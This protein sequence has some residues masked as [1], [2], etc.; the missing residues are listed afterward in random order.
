YLT[1]DWDAHAKRE[2][3]EES[4]RTTGKVGAPTTWVLS[5]HDVARHVTRYG[6]GDHALGLRRARA[7]AL[8]MLA[9]PGSTYIYQGEELGLPEVVELPD[10][11]R[12]DPSFFRSD[13]QEGLRD[14]CRVPL[15]WSGDQAPY[16]FGPGGSWL[17]QPDSFK[18]LTVEAQTGD[19]RSTLE[20]YRSALAL[21][22]EL[23]GL[24]DGPM[25]WL[26]APDGVLAVGRPGVV[27]TL[28]TTGGTVEVPTPGRLLIASVAPA[29]SG[30][31]TALS[32][33][34]CAWWAI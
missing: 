6:G 34:S 14:G 31:T 12:Q 8:L 11:V 32:A 26:P 5:N 13:G 18:G 30:A 4:L 27:C 9:L 29:V 25:S 10:E 22:R 7:A 17:P 23:P 1:V 24:G 28:N 19:P 2:V 16:G 15:P 21:R 33:D 20:L 3:I